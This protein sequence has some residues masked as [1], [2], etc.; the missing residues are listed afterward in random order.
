MSA[1]YSVQTYIWDQGQWTH[2]PVVRRVAVSP[3]AAAELELGRDLAD[4]GTVDCLAVR[5]WEAGKAKLP[6]DVQ[7]YW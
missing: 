7:Y 6:S 2:G 1:V 4:S 5:A 3:R